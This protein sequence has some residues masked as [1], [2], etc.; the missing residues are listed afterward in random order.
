MISHRPVDSV[1]SS[2]QDGTLWLRVLQ[3]L[4][5]GVAVAGFSGLGLA[6][7]PEVAAANGFCDLGGLGIETAQDVVP[8]LS[9]T[10]AQD[11]CQILTMPTE[12]RS[13]RDTF[14]SQVEPGSLLE[15]TSASAE[16]MTLP[17]MWWTRDSIPQ[18]LGRHR[19]VDSWV[20]YTILGTEVRVVD[21][22]ISGQFWRALTMPQR[23]GVLTQFGT[24]AQEFGYHLRF[25]QNNG[26]SARMIGFYACDASN[27]PGA[28]DLLLAS[29]PACLVTVDQPRIQGLQQALRTPPAIQTV[30][31]PSALLTPETTSTLAEFPASLPRRSGLGD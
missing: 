9:D 5:W 8:S 17:S 14:R 1:A 15:N 24:S 29:S 19:L 11:V 31:N 28:T 26:Y 18:R 4:G 13:D 25:F 10:F 3:G 27:S 20:S 22:M 12:S 6:I 21:V 2:P 30:S 16:A 7:T 23:Y